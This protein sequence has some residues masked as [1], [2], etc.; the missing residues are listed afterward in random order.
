MTRP[1]SRRTALWLAIGAG[2]L[3][4]GGANAHLVYVAVT[5]QPACVAQRGGFGAAESACRPAL[6]APHSERGRP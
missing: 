1:R 3:L 4:I 6:P 5:S 2:L